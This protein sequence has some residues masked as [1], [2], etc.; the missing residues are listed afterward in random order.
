MDHLIRNLSKSTK[1]SF[2]IPLFVIIEY[3]SLKFL[4]T[5][6]NEKIGVQIFTED[7]SSYLQEFLKIINIDSKWLEIHQTDNCDKNKIN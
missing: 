7:I 4:V 6:K 1:I 5:S 2:R 3:K